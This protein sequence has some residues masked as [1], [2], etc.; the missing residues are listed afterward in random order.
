MLLI[1]PLPPGLGEATL[2]APAEAD[3][4][5]NMTNPAIT[6]TAARA[7]MVFIHRTPHA[8]SRISGD[9]SVPNHAFEPPRRRRKPMNAVAMTTNATAFIGFRRR[10]GGSDR[11]STRLNSSHT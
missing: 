7:I 10:R 8:R 6:A 3:V 5:A 2:L 9:G 4:H 11:K 1:Y